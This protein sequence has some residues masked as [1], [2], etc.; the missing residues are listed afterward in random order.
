MLQ[1]E[2]LQ[3]AP[4]QQHQQ[5]QQQQQHR[6]DGDEDLMS[7]LD[8]AVAEDTDAAPMAAPQ[9][10]RQEIVTNLLAGLTTSFAAIA[11]GAAFGVA[12]GRGAL[13]G[14]LSAGCI[15]LVTA[16]LGG[17]RVQC[18]GPT[19]PMTT[20]TTLFVAYSRQELLQ[21]GTLSPEAWESM[22]LDPGNCTD[23]A[24]DF[25]PETCPLPD[26]FCNIVMLLGALSIALM[27]VCRV[28]PLISHVPNVVISGFMNGIA[29]QI[30]QK[31]I[32]HLVGAKSMKG[33][34][35]FN[36]PV[37]FCTTALC[38]F[39]PRI[40]RLLLPPK[41]AKSMPGTLIAIMIMTLACVPLNDCL[42]G[43]YPD[44]ST[45]CIEKT[46]LGATISSFDDV[47]RL[48]AA[49]IPSASVWTSEILWLALPWAL[50]LGVLCY[51]DTLLTS[52]V[53]DKLIQERDKSDEVTHKGQ[54]LFAQGLANAFVALFGGLPGAQA[55]IRSVLILKEGGTMRLAGT[56]AGVFVMVEMLIFQ[57]FVKLIPQA[58]FTGAFFLF[59]SFLAIFDL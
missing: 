30:W 9:S 31:Q 1:Q 48:V 44:D 12:S 5:Q 26:Y 22:S 33:S 39:L 50:Q 42:L 14:I 25:T 40:L 53:V 8:R 11:L 19:A 3:W 58:V 7:A 23:A 32:G 52:L 54:E 49:Q 34:A 56:A 20:V 15:A 18:S 4:S 47:S 46:A 35:L 38:F 21:P 55:T 51:L 37:T 29:V 10:L 36:W 17:T 59:F 41:V 6:A 57:N 24:G 2:R 28:G 16:V 13:V 45:A 43:D 27:G